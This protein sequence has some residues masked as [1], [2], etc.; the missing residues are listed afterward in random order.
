MSSIAL[1]AV[2][3]CGRG[4]GPALP[5]DD[6]PPGSPRAVAWVAFVAYVAFVAGVKDLRLPR[7]VSPKPGLPGA[8]AGVKA[9]AVTLAPMVTCLTVG[10]FGVANSTCDDSSRVD[11]D[12]HAAVGKMSFQGKASA[13]H[14]GL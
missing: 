6:P 8:V 11:C 5:A 12:R 13:E 1:S 7:A 3:C 9:A 10:M 4:C 2:S 14:P